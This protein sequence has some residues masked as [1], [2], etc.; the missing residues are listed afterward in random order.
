MIVLEVLGCSG[1]YFNQI[2][3]W[4]NNCIESMRDKI[5]INKRKGVN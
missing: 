5:I 2:V 4:S 1:Y 3:V